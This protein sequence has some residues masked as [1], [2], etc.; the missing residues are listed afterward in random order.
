MEAT[1][2]Q[3]LAKFRADVA[4]F[5]KRVG[6]VE[7]Q[8][9]R[10]Q[11]STNETSRGVQDAFG[12]M[13][14]AAGAFAQKLGVVSAIAGTAFVAIGM[15]SFQ[16]AAEVEELDTVMQVVGST[17]GV[18]YQK[19]LETADAIRDNGIEYASA[20]QMAI[21][22]A[23]NSLEVGKAADI[24]RVAQ[25]LA[26]ISQ[27]NSTDTANRLTHA[28]LNLNSMMLRNA[29][30]QTTVA[31]AVRAY[32]AEN[33]IAVKSMTT[34][35]KQQA[36]LN[37]ILKEG[38]KITG[39]YT[40]SMTNAGKVIRSFPRITKQ[41]QVA[42][43]QSLIKPLG[44][45][46]LQIYE[47]YKNFANLF[48]EGAA[49]RPVIDA[50]TAVLQK[51]VDPLTAGVEKAVAFAKNIKP[52]TTSIGEMGA[53]IQRYLPVIGALGAGLATLGGA[54][55]LSKVPVLGDL[56]GALNP[57]LVGF[58]VLVAL[59]PKIRDAFANLFDAV[60]PSI[61]ILGE[62][63]DRLVGIANIL[64]SGLAAAIN[65]VADFFR[66][67][68]MTVGQSEEALDLLTSVAIAATIVA[69]GVLIKRMALLIKQKIALFI[70]I[71]AVVA[72]LGLFYY[73]MYKAWNSSENFRKIMIQLTKV[74]LF[75]AENAVE[76]VR[77]LV[78]AL[79][80]VVRAAA[81]TLIAWGKL[82]GDTEKVT[83]GKGILS[84]IDKVNGMF[85]SFQKTIKNARGEV[86]KFNKPF[87][88]SDVLQSVQKFIPGMEK[89]KEI[90]SG[91]AAPTDED[92]G[93]DDATSKALAK[94]L[95]G[96]KDALQAYNDY[97]KYDFAVGFTKSSE[98]ARDAVLKSLDSVKRVFDAASEG[99]EGVALKKIQDTYSKLDK[100][101]RDMIPQAE[102]IGA[103]FEKINV[104]LEDATRRLETAIQNRKEAI[105]ELS[106]MMREPFG[107]PSEIQ[108]GLSSANATVD[109]IIS[110]YD[111]L[112][113]VVTK[114]FTGFDD[115]RK[116]AVL[117]YLKTTT[118]MLVDL[119][120]ERE[121][122]VKLWEE[123]KAKLD[124]L[125]KEQDSFAKSLASSIKDYG[126]A[127]VDLSDNN[128]AA[129]IKA[130]K[131][132][133]GVIITQTKKAA[134][135]LDAVTKQLRD[136]LANIK[137]FANN[138]RTLLSRGLDKG[139][140]RQLL[141]AGPE[142]AGQLTAL[143]ANAGGDQL[144]EINNLYKEISSTSTALGQEM[145]NTLYKD[146]V[147]AL[148]KMVD[149]SFDKV[150]DLNNAMT[151]IRQGMELQLAPLKDFMAN[152]GKDSA[153]A[154]Y[155]ALLAKKN[156]LITL[157]NSIAAA[158]AAAMASAMAS[159]GV[160]GAETPNLI[161][162]E[163]SAFDTAIKES[164]EASAAADE[165]WADATASQ[166]ALNTALANL[167]T[168]TSEYTTLASQRDALL[169]QST[170]L[171]AILK[172]QQG[173]SAPTSSK[174]KGT[175]SSSGTKSG[176]TN[177]TLIINSS[178]GSP[179]PSQ[180]AAYMAA[181]LKTAKSKRK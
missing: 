86:D 112:V 61:S 89:I 100:V 126:T 57:V 35:Q 120:R 136:R 53:Q 15:K 135:G 156:D 25:D 133:T 164:L 102:Q 147:D 8:L 92:T 87:K 119:A 131:T 47:L 71:Y 167:D 84:G 175:V 110:T 118:G 103:A 6:E 148:Q 166:T 121:K 130:V 124:D 90:F 143:L 77:M 145:G 62:F 149:A 46:I 98:S 127:L 60:Q 158:I 91:A 26:V 45:L 72:A 94:R 21:K 81:N 66:N 49:L 20:Q 54:S 132:A 99:L 68:T 101:V 177:A 38:A 173:A 96:I 115:A 160:K 165:A 139:Y 18:T 67:F 153:Q 52:I 80:L 106:A 125:L 34:S 129:V 163:V 31:Q 179:S 152:L 75:F 111:R 168:K 97:I 161:P 9:T 174:P 37:A 85:E 22:F 41:L 151:I 69:V 171:M 58:T 43:G 123:Q 30:V 154:L 114:R 56:L 109:S 76:G 176:S 172:K 33:N 138:I 65:K 7:N 27:A 24:A 159:M 13:E 70:E 10:L 19:L 29:G 78:S 28:V 95:Q 104:E 1:V 16:A 93:K 134:S 142:A 88:F 23:K 162:P 79:S 44:P 155:D 157:A 51:L 3:I 2:V 117:D 146:Q 181:T 107:E 63:L 128:E 73:A 11:K 105:N 116:N 17:T 32:S 39:V 40:M 180:V 144:A 82:T 83:F 122:A 170:A 64:I 50:L 59:S 113:E 36:V 12:K 48:E 14:D 150:T 74:M 137:A 178:G 108:K 141:E 42:F 5:N 140:I 169:A 55:L 4:D